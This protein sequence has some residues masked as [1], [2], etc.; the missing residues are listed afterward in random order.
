M[1]LILQ[2]CTLKK[3]LNLIFCVFYHY[4]KVSL[5]SL[6]KKNRDK[7]DQAFR[8]LRGFLSKHGIHHSQEFFQT[9][10]VDRIK[11]E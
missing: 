3:W 7:Y 11:K 2:N 9:Q 4:R 5:K 6:I 8:S 1:Y 10:S